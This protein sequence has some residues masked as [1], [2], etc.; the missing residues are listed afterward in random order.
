MSFFVFIKFIKQAAQGS[1][2]KQNSLWLESL[3]RL[4]LLLTCFQPNVIAAPQNCT[5]GLL[6]SLGLLWCQNRC[7]NGCCQVFW[8]Q[9]L[10]WGEFDWY[11]RIF[12]SFFSRWIIVLIPLL[13]KWQFKYKISGRE[14]SIFRMKFTWYEEPRCSW[15]H[16]QLNEAMRQAGFS[17]RIPPAGGCQSTVYRNLMGR[18][19]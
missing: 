9:S 11:G 19:C 5:L 14:F 8:D 16:L 12:F 10:K 4:Y 18:L 17:S 6:V 1:W 7:T 15:G 3:S 13:I 2:N